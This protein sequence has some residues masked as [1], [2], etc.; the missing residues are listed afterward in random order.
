MAKVI[1]IGEPVND[2]ERLAIAHLRDHLTDAYTVIHN[3]E[4]VRD[5][6][7]FEVDLAVLAPHAVY[8]IDV[9]GVRGLVESYGASWYPDGRA[10]YRS[11]L[12]NLNGHARALQGLL[13][14]SDPSR[15]EL[16]RLHVEAV[17]LLT[18]PDAHF[19]DKTGQEGDAVVTLKKCAGFF[20]NAAR[21]PARFSHNIGVLYGLVLQ[22]LRAK[23]RPRSGPLRFDHWIVDEKLGGIEAYTEYRGHNAY[24]GPRSGSVLL[25]A[26]KADPYLPG[27]EREAQQRRIQN[28]Y[29][30]LARLTAHPGVAGVR[31]FF[32]TEDHD[33]YILVTEDV[34]AAP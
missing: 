3:F 9:K 7:S 8:L 24:A 5:G 6:D 4:I 2:A 17:V 1:P 26:Y 29:R 14:D 22:A 23:A 20:N 16:Q 33:R 10:P 18:A 19:V 27:P 25:R 31:D 11:P 15:P 30:A 32:P 34:S 12:L 21:V 13:S 28:A